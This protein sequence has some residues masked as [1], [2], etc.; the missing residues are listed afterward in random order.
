MLCLLEEDGIPLIAGEISN[1]AETSVI[2]PNVT[3]YRVG[4]QQIATAVVLP[5]KHNGDPLPVLFDPYGGPHCQRV[6]SQSSLYFQSQW[7]ANQGFCV[8]LFFHS[9]F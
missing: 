7:F 5:H 4:P 2:T 8:V 9:H 6:L 3:I 1:N